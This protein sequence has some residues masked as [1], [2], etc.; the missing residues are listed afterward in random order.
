MSRFRKFIKSRLLYTMNIRTIIA[1]WHYRPTHADTRACHDHG[2][3]VYRVCCFC[4]N[5]VF[6]LQAWAATGVN[7]SRITDIIT[8]T[9]Q[10]MNSFGNCMGIDI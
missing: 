8:L 6:I 1:E 4:H 2:Q 7:M 3:L 9:I 10:I 5:V